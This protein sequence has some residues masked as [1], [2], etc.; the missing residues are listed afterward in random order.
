MPLP[1]AIIPFS[2][3]DVPGRQSTVVFFAGCNLNCIFCHNHGMIEEKNGKI[4]IDTIARIVREEGFI[5]TL[6]ISGGEPSI[7]PGMNRFITAVKQ[8]MVDIYTSI[9]MNGTNPVAIKVIAP[10]VDRVAVDFKAGSRNWKDILRPRMNIDY[11]HD[12]TETIRVASEMVKKVDVRIT[13]SPSWIND[14]DVD[15]FCR[16]IENAG[17]HGTIIIQ[18]F[19]NRNV[20]DDA[21]TITVPD[22]DDIDHVVMALRHAGLSNNIITP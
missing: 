9:D 15:E 2:L 12:F 10:I 19:D 3:S 13:Y 11:H 18:K 21:K 14:M 17:F 8:K 7:K 20:R 16:L 1:S 22:D 6:C 4:P 5:D